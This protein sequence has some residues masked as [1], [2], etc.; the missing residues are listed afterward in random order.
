MMSI[1]VNANGQVCVASDNYF[2]AMPDAVS[3]SR[4]RRVLT[5]MFANGDEQE[6]GTAGLTEISRL[7]TKVNSIRFMMLRPASAASHAVL[8]LYIREDRAAAR[9]AA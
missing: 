7:L 3:Y 5:L 6:L 8:P 1:L 2:T 9:V 4:L